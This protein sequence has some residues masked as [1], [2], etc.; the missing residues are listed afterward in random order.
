LNEAIQSIARKEIRKAGKTLVKDGKLINFETNG[1][2]APAPVAAMAALM[3]AARGNSAQAVDLPAL[4]LP[5]VNLS[6]RQLFA[7]G[8]GMATLAYFGSTQPAFAVNDA[9]I[10][11]VKRATLSFGKRTA[12]ATVQ[13]VGSLGIRG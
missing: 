7:V 11:T 4:S 9:Y 12:P 13:T 3:A 2:A 8:A 1:V 5:E 10:S 6:R